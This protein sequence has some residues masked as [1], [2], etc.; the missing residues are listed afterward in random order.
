LPTTTTPPLCLCLA[1]RCPHTV[2]SDEDAQNSADW[3]ILL[4][5]GGQRGRERPQL[6]GLSSASRTQW[7]LHLNTGDQPSPFASNQGSQ[8][9]DICS[10]KTGIFQGGQDEQVTQGP[11]LQPLRPSSLTSVA[12]GLTPASMRGA[13]PAVVSSSMCCWALPVVPGDS[14]TL[15]SY[16]SPKRGK[17]QIPL[18]FGGVYGRSASWN[19]HEQTQTLT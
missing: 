11:S 1:A 17:P 19:V 12:F 4:C 5:S 10:T 8:Q 15:D 9:D 7:H 2:A 13:F 14:V 18:S 16:H 6:R 3:G